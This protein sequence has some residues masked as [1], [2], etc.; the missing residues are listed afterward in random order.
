MPKTGAAKK[1]R[2]LLKHNL[3]KEG[4]SDLLLLMNSHLPKPSLFTASTYRFKETLKMCISSLK[5]SSKHKYCGH[6]HTLLIKENPCSN[7]HCRNKGAKKE[8]F[9]D[10]HME[11][12][13]MEFFKGM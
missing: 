4:F 8:E 11:N 5:D 12:Q 7:E 10:L 3:S 13:L 2:W 6:C 1:K 9:Y